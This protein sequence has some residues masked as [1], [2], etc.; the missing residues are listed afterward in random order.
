MV[1]F[2]PTRRLLA[3]RKIKKLKLEQGLARDVLIVSSTGFRTFV[4][5]QGDFHSVLQGCREARIM[6]LN[7][8]SEGAR[9]RAMSMLNPGVTPG[10]LSEQIKKSIDFLKGLKAA[11]KNIKLKLYDDPPFLKLAILGDYIWMKHYH[12]GIDVQEM[13]EYVFAHDQNP[14]TLYAP[15]YQYFLMRWNDSHIPEYDLDTDELVYRDTSGNETRREK[16][17]ECE[18]GVTG[19]AQASWSPGPS[20]PL[21]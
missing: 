20:W 7:P 10:R 18:I 4:D 19:D 16:F 15:F 9:V 6:L 5:P 13:P 1:Y 21:T 3:Q 17:N 11:Q 12:P 2:F 14:G 8:Q